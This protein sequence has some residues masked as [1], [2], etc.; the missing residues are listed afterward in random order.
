LKRNFSTSSRNSKPIQQ[1]N[2]DEV[3]FN[4]S[5]FCK[6]E[7]STV[8]QVPLPIQQ[9]N[10]ER[11]EPSSVQKRRSRIQQF[12][13]ERSEPQQRATRASTASNASLNSEQREPHQFSSTK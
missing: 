4:S 5:T 1:F 10:G 11:S 13:S 7:S 12:N 9:F 8:P 2:S 3:A 6:V